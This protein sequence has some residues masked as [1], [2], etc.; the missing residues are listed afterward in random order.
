MSALRK[1]SGKKARNDWK[2]KQMED[3]RPRTRKIRGMGTMVGRRP[4]ILTIGTLCLQA[5]KAGDRG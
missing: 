1:T 5:S 3:T 2:G 4:I